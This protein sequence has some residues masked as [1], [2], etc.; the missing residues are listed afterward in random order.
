M[1]LTRWLAGPQLRSMFV[2]TNSESESLGPKS[3]PS[4]A[5]SL[6]R[7]DQNNQRR[8]KTQ[9]NEIRTPLNPSSTYLHQPLGYSS[10]SFSK[11]CVSETVGAAK[12]GKERFESIF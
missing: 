7:K 3:V 6:A 10:H 9:T 11:L 5:P 12:K 8:K 2:Y 1:R 4:T